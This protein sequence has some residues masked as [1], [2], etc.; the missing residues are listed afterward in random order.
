MGS[1][2]GMEGKPIQDAIIDVATTVG[3]SYANLLRIPE[4]SYEIHLTI[5]HSVD[6]RK[7]GLSPLISQWSRFASQA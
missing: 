3:N 6:K 1:E 4:E 7:K 2:T 5:V